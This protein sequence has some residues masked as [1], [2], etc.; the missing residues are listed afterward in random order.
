MFLF[1]FGDVK[2]NSTVAIWGG[3]HIGKSYIQQII[4][5]KYVKIECV[6]DKKD[7][8]IEGVKTVKPDAIST[9]DVDYLIIAIDDNSVEEIIKKELE[10]H[11]I[12]TK[13]IHNIIYCNG[14]IGNHHYREIVSYTLSNPKYENTLRIDG[15]KKNLLLNILGA[16]HVKNVENQKLVRVGGDNDGG[17]LMIDD[18]DN[19][20]IAYSFGIGNNI[21]WD[22]DVA[23]R[24]L[25]VYMYDHTVSK[26]T[27]IE[28]NDKLHFFSVGLAATEDENGR[29][30]TLDELIRKNNHLDNRNMI[31]KM[32]IEG[33]EWDALFGIS[34]DTLNRFQQIVIELH[35]LMNETRWE[36]YLDVLNQIAQTHQAVHVNA[37]NTC[38]YITIDGVI[39]PDTLEVTFYRI[40][41]SSFREL[42]MNEPFYDC[43][44]QRNVEYLDEIVL[45]NWNVL[46]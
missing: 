27:D 14:P 37:N 30:A 4:S 40:E 31:L 34:E 18:F 13:V 7:V 11:N 28:T 42:K 8:L 38:A 46:L 22:S 25:D 32:D 26:I 19:K 43:L 21:S 1:P 41:G 33:A 6:I 3:G 36:L 29:F 45:G 12:D 44:D 17:Y 10:K 35:G 20:K 2:Y 39:I 15:E 16:I 24:G 9:L 23:S 5:T